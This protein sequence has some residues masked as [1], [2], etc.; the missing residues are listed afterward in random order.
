MPLV[1]ARG[2]H[3]Q[4]IDLREGTKQLIGRIFL[5]FIFLSGVQLAH[6]QHTLPP[7]EVTATTLDGASVMI[8]F[9]MMQYMRLQ[10]NHDVAILDDYITPL[11]HEQVCSNLRARQPTNCSMGTYPSASGLRDAQ[12]HAFLGNGCGADAYSS[13]I[14]DR[15]LNAFSDGYSGDL[16][17]PVSQDRAIDFTG[18]CNNHDRCYTSLRQKGK[19]DSQLASDLASV[20]GGAAPAFASTCNEFLAFYTAAVAKKGDAAYY[21]D[22]KNLECS[23]WGNAMKANK[24]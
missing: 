15:L 14:G 11:T 23:A 7:V 19:C 5:V 22:Q 21:A 8:P 9:Q 20:C 18:A 24:C 4:S 1:A 2:R 10:M 12:G 13:Y 3:L 6:A 17:R 16:N